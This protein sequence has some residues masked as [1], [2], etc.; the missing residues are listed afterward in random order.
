MKRIFTMTPFLI[1]PIFLYNCIA[2]SAGTLSADSPMPIDKTLNAEVFSMT[3]LSGGIWTFRLQ[4][5]ILLFALIALFVELIK[6]TSTRTE[7]LVNH[8]LSI[9][10][11]LFCLLEFIVFDRFASSTFFLLIIAAL[12]DVIA[13]FVITTV[14]A[15]RDIGVGHGI[16]S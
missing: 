16:V 10:L 1:G 8:G 2:L 11:L 6:A 12:L 3:M 5:L 4:D 14:A 13:G 9:G 15:R 7:S